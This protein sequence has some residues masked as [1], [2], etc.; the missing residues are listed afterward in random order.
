MSYSNN[1]II[2]KPVSKNE[3]I[4]IGEYVASRKEEYIKKTSHM[5]LEECKKEINDFKEKEMKKALDEIEKITEDAYRSGR[6]KAKEEAILEVRSDTEQSMRIEWEERFSKIESLYE[7][8]N[9]YQKEIKQKIEEKKEKWLEENDRELLEIVM[10]S[11]KKI[12]VKESLESSDEQVKGIIK[13]AIDQVNDKSKTIWIRVHPKVK[14]K[15]E[16]QN[17][18]ERKIE[19]IADIK[20]NEFDVLVETESEW[21]DSTIQNKINNLKKIIEEWV[22]NND[23]LN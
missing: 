8:A 1:K 14:E 6:E 3:N 18:Y 5:K 11:V 12:L 17:W 19:W 13:E 16:S 23:L 7:E 9:H 21:I 2:K 10:E 22:L 20:L 15:I 4:H